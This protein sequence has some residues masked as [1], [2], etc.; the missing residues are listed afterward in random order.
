MWRASVPWLSPH[1]CREPGCGVLIR[2]PA[3]RCDLHRSEQR[4]KEDSLRPGAKISSR[5]INQIA[6]DVG[7]GT[8]FDFS[9]FILRFDVAM[10]VRDPSLPKGERWLVSDI[11]FGSSAWRRSNLV[12]NLAIGYP[13]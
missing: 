6:M 1:P 10:P 8:R 5:F 3:G 9:Y 4:K 11:S 7:I 12:L 2:G 13:F